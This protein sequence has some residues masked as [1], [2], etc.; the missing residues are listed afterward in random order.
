MHSI[1][2]AAERSSFY[3]PPRS[4]APLED[5]PNVSKAIA[6][7]AC[8]IAAQVGAKV[9]VAFTESG[10]TASYVSSA[11]PR[12]PI[13]GL[14]PNQSTLRRLC[15]MW[16]VVPRFVESL[17]DSDEMVDR[18]HTLL[19]SSGIVNTGDRFVAI[20]GAPVGVAGSTNAIQVKVVT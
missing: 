1:I 20:F 7:G 9:I 4:P 15:L 13:M 10:K 8:Q 3:A 6:Y 19:S 2:V 17:R 16:G 5:R 18:A 11:R 12:I 14:S